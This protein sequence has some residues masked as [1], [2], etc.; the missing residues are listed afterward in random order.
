MFKININISISIIIILIA[1]CKYENITQLQK[2]VVSIGLKSD[3]ALIEMSYEITTYQWYEYN[4]DNLTELDLAHLN[5]SEE[6]QRI[7][8]FLM[9]DG[10]VNMITEELDFERTI[11]IPSEI[12]PCDEPKIKRTELIG[13][14]VTF[15]DGSRNVLGSH[16]VQMQRQTELANQ[17]REYGERFGYEEAARCF[18]T[19]Q[20]D[21]FDLQMDEMIAQAEAKGQLTIHDENFSTVRA[22]FADVIPGSSGATVVI[23]DRNIN[24]M[25]ASVVYDE[26]ENETSR[27][28]LGYEKDGAPILNET[29]TTQIMQLPSGAKVW[30]I[31]YSK[32]DNLKYNLKN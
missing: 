11:N 7:E 30:Q 16:S 24:K 3:G 12:A 27:T 26:M 20:G 29:M 21:I 28:Y 32:I 5:P 2:D 19:M 6:K 4:I 13:N 14:T 18:A 17:L 8:M 10:T 15:Y 25:V 9:Y 1:G 22:N 23:V 31:T